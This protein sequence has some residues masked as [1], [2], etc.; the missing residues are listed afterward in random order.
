MNGSKRMAAPGNLGIFVETAS[1]QAYQVKVE[2]YAPL[3]V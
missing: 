1:K 3:R 2:G